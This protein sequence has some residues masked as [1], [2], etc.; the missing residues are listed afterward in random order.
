MQARFAFILAFALTA[1][2]FNAQPS[3]ALLFWDWDVTNNGA[4]YSTTDEVTLLARLTNNSTANETI[5]GGNANYSVSDASRSNLFGY[6]APAEPEFFDQFSALE[7]APGESFNFTLTHYVPL[8]DQIAA[9]PYQGKGT[10]YLAKNN[11]PISIFSAIPE[12]PLSIDKDFNWTVSETEMPPSTVPEPMTLTLF[13]S[14]L[15]AGIFLKKR[16]T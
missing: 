11:S 15:L 1:T 3:H 8:A 14:G 4:T 2:V 13:G 12:S 6:L 10:L 16:K 9:G 7:L 5:G